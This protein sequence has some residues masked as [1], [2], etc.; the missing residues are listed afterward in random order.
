MDAPGFDR[1]GIIGLGSMGR[2]LAT[3]LLRAGRSLTVYDIRPESADDLLGDTPMASSPRQVAEEADVVLIIVVDEAQV[4]DVLWGPDGLMEAA[5]ADLSVLVISTI[6]IPAVLDIADRAARAGVTLIDCGVTGGEVAAEKGVVSMVGGDNGAVERVRSVLDDFSS[7][8]FHMGP[9]GAGMTAKLARNVIT[10]CSW[11]VVY[12]A[13]LL[14]E[15]NGVDL[16]VLSEVIESSYQGAGGLTVPWRRGTV[17]PMDPAAEN[18]DPRQFQRLAGAVGLLRKD[19]TA[20]EDLAEALQVDLSV[21]PP[22]RA[23][24]ERIFGVP[25]EAPAGQE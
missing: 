12:Q 13:G 22:T 9:L 7:H 25:I 15:R 20:A 3:C 24:A 5:R 23:D 14:A 17:A 18:F 6:G 19:L 1:V 16:A 10:Y 4:R 11:H 8:V 2:A 21:A